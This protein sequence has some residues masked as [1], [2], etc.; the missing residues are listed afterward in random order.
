MT[1]KLY[2]V[3]GDPMPHCVPSGFEHVLPAGSVE[4]TEERAAEMRAALDP[5]TAQKLL[6]ALAAEYES[7]MFI[8]AADYPPSER[9]SWPVQTSEARALL[10]DVGANT[11]WIDAA[12]SARGITRLELATRIVSKDNAFR[13]VSGTLTGLRQAI[14]DQITA[15]GTD[16]QALAAIDVTA[17][18][19]QL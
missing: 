16:P 3:P 9:E 18:W 11:P 6:A 12:S 19:P 2:E 17:G 14:E 15:A 1:E 4:I 8:I 10:A 5:V 7:R 13:I